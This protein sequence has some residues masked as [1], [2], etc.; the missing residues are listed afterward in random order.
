MPP[1][2]TA[3][4]PLPPACCAVR[5]GE[6]VCAITSA[7]VAGVATHGRAGLGSPEVRGGAPWWGY[8]EYPTMRPIL[9]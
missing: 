6:G 1:S 5:I 4:R 9:P 3:A 7:D 2:L 8:P